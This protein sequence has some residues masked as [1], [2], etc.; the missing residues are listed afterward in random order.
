MSKSDLLT[1]W[2]TGKYV[3]QE[4]P[5]TLLMG[6]RINGYIYLGDCLPTCCGVEE[7]HMSRESFA[8][9]LKKKSTRKFELALYVTVR[10][11]NN[12]NLH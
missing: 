5:L 1:G 7:A 2:A 9:V 11:W 6:M 4:N 12:L 10:Y 3:E 8:H